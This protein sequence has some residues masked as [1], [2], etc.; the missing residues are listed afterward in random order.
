M[1][2]RGHGC[3]HKSSN[4]LPVFWSVPNEGADIPIRNR[5]TILGGPSL[6]EPMYLAC[7]S[8]ERDAR[9]REFLD[10]VTIGRVEYLAEELA[11][12]SSPLRE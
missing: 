5:P 9:R 2:C 8:Q 4:V 3:Y 12:S 6:E 11:L 1:Q 10:Q 7:M